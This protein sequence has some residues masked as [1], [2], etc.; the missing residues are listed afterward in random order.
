[1]ESKTAVY[2]IIKRVVLV[3][4]IFLFFVGYTNAGESLSKGES[5]YVSIYS[6]VYSGVKLH[7]LELSGMLSIRNTDPKYSISIQKADY[8]D[9]K[10]ELLER[11]I[12]QPLKLKAL[13]STHFLVKVSDK[14]GGPGANFIVKWQSDNKVNQPIIEGVML[15]TRAQ[16][17]IS[18]ICP[19][20]IISEHNE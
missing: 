12:T 8:Y 3:V 10:G 6:N 17:G 15:S 16:Q 5:V 4:F 14:R 20:K 13:E 11:Y 7:A 2:F 1:M 19:G 9:S 18:F